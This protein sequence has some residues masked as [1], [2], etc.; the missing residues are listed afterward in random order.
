MQNGR[1]RSDC[2]AA[3]AERSLP[4]FTQDFIPKSSPSPPY[5]TTG[6]G[7]FI[8]RLCYYQNVRLCSDMMQLTCILYRL[9]TDTGILHT[10]MIN[11]LAF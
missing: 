11:K 5:I 7:S 6:G 10:L 1:L 3:Q 2:A 8:L 4:G 9:F